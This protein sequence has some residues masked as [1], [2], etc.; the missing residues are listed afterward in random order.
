MLSVFHLRFVAG[1][2]ATTACPINIPI[3][4]ARVVRSQLHI[5]ACEFSWLARSTQRIRL[6][7]MNQTLL[8]CA[9]RCLKRSPGGTRRDS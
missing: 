5:D 3:R 8:R 2:T 9:A 1:L 4:I 7:E 6:T